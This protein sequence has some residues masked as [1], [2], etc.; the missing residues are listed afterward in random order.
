MGRGWSD[1]LDAWAAPHAPRLSP[2]D[3]YAVSAFVDL[4]DADGHSIA[5]PR[6]VRVVP[7]ALAF[8]DQLIRAGDDPSRSFRV[9]DGAEL[10]RIQ[11][12]GDRVS[13]LGEFPERQVPV[14]ALRRALRA[15]LS[16]LQAD[17]QELHTGGTLLPVIRNLALGEALLSR[18][19]AAPKSKSGRRRRLYQ[20]PPLD[21]HDAPRAVAG[22]A[23]T[24]VETVE[25]LL[26]RA[27][28]AP[29]SA[30]NP[31]D[32]RA[33]PPLAQLHFL[34]LQHAFDIEILSTHAS[35]VFF[36][37]SRDLLLLFPEKIVVVDTQEGAHW[38][39][40]LDIQPE[41]GAPK[42]LG[43]AVIVPAVDGLYALLPD[44]RWTTLVKLEGA[45]HPEDVVALV[46]S[47]V[48]A[49]A[50][51]RGHT[52]YDAPTG[53]ATLHELSQLY[54]RHNAAGEVV[55]W[56]ALD[57]E[58]TTIW[59]DGEGTPSVFHESDAPIVTAA[60][61]RHGL[62]TLS[63]GDKLPVIRWLTQDAA[64]AWERSFETRG[65]GFTKFRFRTWPAHDDDRLCFAL[66]AGHMW[67]AFGVHTRTRLATLVLHH[68]EQAAVRVEWG[69]GAIVVA[70]GERLRAYPV[71]GRM[72]EPLWEEKVPNELGLLAPVFPVHLR[73]ELLVHAT[74]T[75]V[76]R[77][78]YSGEAIAEYRGAWTA[79]FDVRLDDGLGVSVIGAVPGSVIEIFRAEAAHWL[80]LVRR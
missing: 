21:L 79:V 62:L 1:T 45:Y 49:L 16:E 36:G 12:R 33:A 4:I 32:T 52:V 51:L 7:F 2:D 53:A 48:E 9:D 47:P 24:H 68:R 31:A 20:S 59:W 56:Y 55:G 39:L 10:F 38:A 26:R 15:L 27:S 37:P 13:I 30:D 41:H 65:E 61:T 34:S 71:E 66:V 25:S 78:L 80:G 35:D 64:L 46:A 60:S 18:D 14:D 8:V 42:R 69:E 58:R 75:A 23:P 22:S 43:G 54:P 67:W 72:P 17:L 77:R 29:S 28:E 40:R 5:L 19:A 44:Q 11:R 76:V 70:S 6:V 50:Y 3:A 63:Q 57:R 73:G 74:N